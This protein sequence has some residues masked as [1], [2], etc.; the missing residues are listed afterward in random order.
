MQGLSDGNGLRFALVD[1][2]PLCTSTSPR[3]GKTALLQTLI[4][5]PT[6]VP[7]TTLFCDAYLTVVVTFSPFTDVQKIF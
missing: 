3:S 5:L 2:R 4:A 6:N 1:E 7:D